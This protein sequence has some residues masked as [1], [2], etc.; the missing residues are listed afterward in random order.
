MSLQQ[1]ILDIEAELARTQVNKATMHHICLLRAKLAKYKKE[2]LEPKT[3]S[4]PGGEG[5]DVCKFGD[6]RVGMIGFPSVGKSTLLS[7]MTETE[8]RIAAYEF[9]TLTCIPGTLDYNGAKIQFLDLPGIIEGASD[10]KGRGKQVIAVAKSCDC[11][12]LVVDGTKSMELKDKIEFELESFGIRLNKTKPF[13]EFRKKERGGITFGATCKQTS[14]TKDIVSDVLKSEYK[15][16]NADVVCHCDASIQDLIDAVGGGVKYIPCIYVVN[17]IDEMDP[18]VVKELNK[19]DNYVCV[20]ADQ[21]T[22]LEDL[23]EMIWEKIKLIRA[24]PRPVGG[25]P[26]YDKPVVL[27]HSKATIEHFCYKIH[28]HLIKEMKYA[29]VWGTSVKHNPQRVGKDHKLNDEDVVQIV[30]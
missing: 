29:L 13:I 12:L 14:L 5:F 8:S 23:K 11:I 4:G 28:K 10:G 24:Y 9:T 22:N 7:N 16:L 3:K 1:K 26:D 15:V 19:K 30:K 27:P 21:E 6:A 17:K 25:D 20:S 18:K 2:L